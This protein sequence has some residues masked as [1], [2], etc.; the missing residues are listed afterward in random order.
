MLVRVSC[1]IHLVGT[2][3]P[4]YRSIAPPRQGRTVP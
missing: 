1:C 4:H 3:S 2:L